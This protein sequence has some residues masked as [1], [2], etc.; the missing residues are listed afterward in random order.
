MQKKKSF[1]Y[2]FYTFRRPE[3]QKKKKK[4]MQ[5]VQN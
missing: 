1:K 5:F 2:I 4:V 3:S